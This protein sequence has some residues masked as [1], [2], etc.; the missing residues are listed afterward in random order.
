M[1]VLGALNL[2]FNGDSLKSV[3]KAKLYRSLM[4]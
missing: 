4:N 3:F 1:V 2:E